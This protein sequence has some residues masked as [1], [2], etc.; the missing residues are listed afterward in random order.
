[1]TKL[2]KRARI[3]QP[4]AGTEGYWII[5]PIN[6]QNTPYFTTSLKTKEAGISV[7]DFFIVF[8]SYRF[9]PPLELWDHNAVRSIDERRMVIG[10]RGKESDFWLA[11][12]GESRVMWHSL[13]IRDVGVSYKERWVGRRLKKNGSVFLCTSYVIIQLNR[14]LGL[15]DQQRLLL[16]NASLQPRLKNL[17]IND[18]GNQFPLVITFLISKCK[19]WFNV[20]G[21]GKKIYL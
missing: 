17:N 3:T 1:M 6:P 11:C 21:E 14:T 5:T 16:A 8:L 9:F 18:Y 7:M 20:G 12:S 2:T 10:E 19:H 4:R 15:L 13:A